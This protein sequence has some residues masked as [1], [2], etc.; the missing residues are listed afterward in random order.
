[1]RSRLARVQW[2]SLILLT[3]VWVMLMGDITLGN[4]LAGALVAAGIMVV[5]PL[6]PVA[7]GIRPH[8]VAVVVLV[9]RFLWDLTVASIQVGW[10]TVRPGRT[11]HGVVVDLRLRTSNELLQTITSQMV[12]LVPGTVVIDMDSQ[13]RLLTLHMLD[14]DSR[15]E[16]EEVRRRVLAQEAR[17]IRALDPDP[18]AV[19]DPRRNQQPSTSAAETTDGREER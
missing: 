5:F 12:G 14:I 2:G 7:V 19:L 6:P 13:N 10:L 15:D 3:I 17:V 4:I 9:L 18:E 16:A 11:V 8:L 1:M